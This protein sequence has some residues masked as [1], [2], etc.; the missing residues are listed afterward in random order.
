MT[1]AQVGELSRLS[2][3]SR[4]LAIGGLAL[5]GVTWPLWRGTSDFPQVP[6][7][8]GARAVPT[9]VDAILLAA[10][11]ASWACTLIRPPPQRAG[12]VALGTASIALAALM[13]L[14]QH[15]I[16]PWAWEFLLVG[17]LLA[18]GGARTGL[19]TWRWLVI[20]IYVWS[21]LSKLDATFFTSH[22][23]FL[24]EGLLKA[25]GQPRALALWSEAA[26]WRLAAAIPLGE[27][28]IA[29]ALL[30]PRLRMLGLVGSIAMHSI[31]LLALGPGGHGHQP[32]VLLWN[33]FFIGQNLLLFGQP[34]PNRTGW[35]DLRPG[36]WAAVVVGLAAVLFPA[37]E[38][39]GRCDHWPGWVVYASRP[40]RVY[41]FVAEADA[42]TLSAEA[43]HFLEP[44]TPWEP[45]RQLRIDRWSLAS[46]LAP[47]YPQDRFAVGIALAIAEGRGTPHVRVLRESAADRWTGQRTTSE[48]V[49]TTAVAEY[50]QAF[51]LNAQPRQK[52]SNR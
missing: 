25:L 13:L 14:N 34:A 44:A 42:D 12:R 9:V 52:N 24:L 36:E 30:V 10:L 15:R 33:L 22:G 37:L 8:S 51:R 39:I 11:L 35:Q 46:T 40:E 31:L 32:G 20:S 2:W 45:W 18:V 41:V 21:A 26:R 16:Q 43:Q 50:S 28:L 49:G 47:I 29:V 7:L 17:L 6:L 4:G 5:L 23:P 1:A 48:F 3:A 38:P 27:L 19:L